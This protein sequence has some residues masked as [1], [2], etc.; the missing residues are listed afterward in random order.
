M[1]ARFLFSPC[2][3]AVAPED[4]QTQEE[5]VAFWLAPYRALARRFH[6]TVAAV[7]CVG[8]VRGGPW[9]G[10]RC[11]GSSVVVDA[12]GRQA[13]IAPYGVEAEALVLASITSQTGGVA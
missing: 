8:F 13:A 3:W 2:A 4:T 6:M 9:D 7:S 10:Y 5:Y 12:D 11:I 1:G